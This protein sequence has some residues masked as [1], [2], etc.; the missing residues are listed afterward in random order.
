MASFASAL[1]FKIR[2]MASVVIMRV[3]PPSSSAINYS[4]AWVLARSCQT[5]VLSTRC[6]KDVLTRRQDSFN[7]Y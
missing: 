1:S 4:P 2:R 6:S 7:R 3:A 5:F